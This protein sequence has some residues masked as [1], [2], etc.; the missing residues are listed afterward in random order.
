MG[1]AGGDHAFELGVGQHAVRDDVGG[2][3]RPIAWLG[4]C[5]RRHRRRLH[6]LGGV[7]LRAGNTDRLQSVSFVKRFGDVTALDRHP[8]DGLIGQLNRLRFGRRG[9]DGARARRNALRSCGGEANRSP[10]DDRRRE[11]EPRRNGFGDPAKQGCGIGRA[12]E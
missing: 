9:R 10:V 2:Q 12:A 6:Q 7:N 3:M 5:H 4:R 1:L 11:R 8:V